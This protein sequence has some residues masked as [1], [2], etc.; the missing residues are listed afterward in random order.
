MTA[1]SHPLAA[2]GVEPQTASTVEAKVARN[3]RTTTREGSGGWR[4]RTR[5]MWGI[6]T[7]L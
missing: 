6:G 5:R 7:S 3:S 1:V 2:P 4:G